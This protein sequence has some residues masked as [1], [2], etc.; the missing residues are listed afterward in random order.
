MINNG[1]PDNP[2]AAFLSPSLLDGGWMARVSIGVESSERRHLAQLRVVL[3]E[4][5]PG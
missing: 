4:H 3:Y 2:G 5:T 1:F